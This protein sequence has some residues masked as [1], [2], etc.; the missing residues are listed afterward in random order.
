[1]LLSIELLNIFLKKIEIK[2]IHHSFLVGSPKNMEER[3]RI[4][5]IKTEA[6]KF[7]A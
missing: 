1:M 7:E 3:K 5:K 4:N 2:K 6:G